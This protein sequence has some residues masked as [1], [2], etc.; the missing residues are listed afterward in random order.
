MPWPASTLP[1][2]AVTVPSDPTCTQASSGRPQPLRR[3][4]GHRRPPRSPAR[5]AAAGRTTR[6]PW[7]PAPTAPA[8]LPRSRRPRTGPAAHGS[9]GRRPAAPA[10]RGAAGEVWRRGS[11]QQ[12]L[13]V[14]HQLGSPAD[15]PQDPRIGAAP[16]D[17]AGQLGR[18]P[19]LAGMGHDGQQRGRGHQPAW[20]AVTALH[21]A[22]LQ[23]GL[24]N[25][26]QDA[27]LGQP[28]DGGDPFPGDLR[29]R[30]YAGRHG[31]APDQDGAG[32]AGALAAAELRAGAA[33]LV[34]EHVEQARSV[35]G[36]LGAAPL[37]MIVMSMGPAV[38][39]AAGGQPAWRRIPPDTISPPTAKPARPPAPGR[40]RPAARGR[41][42]TSTHK[43]LT[44]AGERL[45]AGRT[46]SQAA[47]PCRLA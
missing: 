14:V 19:G 15:R 34:P 46:G 1:V 6:P 5:R 11:G 31:P 39:S 47:R 28:L 16:A 36:H 20:R 27:V 33:H 35:R 9:S 23:P 2:N 12:F 45:A 26:V 32:A 44:V 41:H 18:D 38:L 37:T 4:R 30:R 25:R 8:G 17:L 24:L 43:I 42:S 21:R 7:R 40:S 29:H 3:V 22:G 10:A 13:G